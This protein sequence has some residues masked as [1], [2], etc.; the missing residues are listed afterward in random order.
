MLVSSPVQKN[1]QL[2][3]EGATMLHDVVCLWLWVKE[4][5]KMEFAAGTIEQHAE[6]FL[7]GILGFEI[8]GCSQVGFDGLAA[9]KWGVMGWLQPTHM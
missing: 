7:K 6:K 3:E 4:K 1:Q 5:M 9:A 8:V 2:N